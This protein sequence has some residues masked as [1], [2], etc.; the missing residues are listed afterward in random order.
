[1]SWVQIPPSPFLAQGI[2]ALNQAYF[3]KWWTKAI[4]AVCMLYRKEQ[5]ATQSFEI[6][7]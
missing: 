6:D 1:M 5:N 2:T 3:R 4:I 7:G